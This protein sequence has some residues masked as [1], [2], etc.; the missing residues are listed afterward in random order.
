[1]NLS[2]NAQ[3]VKFPRSNRFLDQKDISEM[4]QAIILGSSVKGNELI[5]VEGG[6]GA[7]DIKQLVDANF[8]SEKG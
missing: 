8:N 5:K 7:S 1:M 3:Q 4:S 2:S 6:G